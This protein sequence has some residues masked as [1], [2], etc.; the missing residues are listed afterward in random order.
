MKAL[1]LTEDRKA[2]REL[3]AGA[4]ALAD[5]VGLI[6]I[7][8]SSV[9]GGSSVGGSD[10]ADGVA[11][12]VLTVTLPDGYLYEEAFET[13]AA[14]V[15]REQPDL[16]L[17][18]PTR[19]V[20]IIAGRLAARLG[21]SVVTEVTSLASGGEA[22]S[23]YFGGAALRRQRPVGTPALYAVNPGALDCGVASGANTPVAV[24]F[25]A[26]AHR[27]TR[28]STRA[29]PAQAVDLTE[30]RRV[31]AIGRG[32]A[33]EAD[34]PLVREFCAAVG[35]ELGCSRPI[36]ETEGWL[37]RGVYIGVSGVSLKPE[38]YVGVGI[39]GQMQHVVGVSRAKVF[40]A[41][42]KD[43]NAPIFKQADLGL[44]GDLY[45]VLPQLTQHLSAR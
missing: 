33:S 18:Q 7:T 17:V 2:S 45:A 44:V 22:T 19:R 31:V 29:L 9:D 42:N 23:M 32:L 35:A 16:V 26:P 3:C 20:K 41:I 25:V 12:R 6:S 38:L 40:A 36:A 8:G 15:T 24:D 14:L 1:I 11:D 27:L 30:A 37:P 34:L 43:K 28:I 5:E 10:V 13:V 21:T 39:S 4:R